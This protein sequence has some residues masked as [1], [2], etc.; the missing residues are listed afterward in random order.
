MFDHDSFLCL[1]RLQHYRL[2][3]IP[4]IK[5]I[6]SP[7]LHLYGTIIAT[8]LQELFH[9]PV[10]SP[11]FEDPKS[12][13]QKAQ[14]H[15]LLWQLKNKWTAKSLRDQHRLLTSLGTL[16]A[17]TK[18]N[19]CGYQQLE[20]AHTFNTTII[21]A[22]YDYRQ[23]FLQGSMIAPLSQWAIQAAPEEQSPLGSLF[24][25]FREAVDHRLASLWYAH[26]TKMTQMS[27]IPTDVPMIHPPTQ[28]KSKHCRPKP[29]RNCSR[30]S[31]NSA[32]PT[33]PIAKTLK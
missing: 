18:K 11:F 29:Y 5:P 9:I 33:M 28:S 19:P 12:L 23:T 27:K 15:N 22:C 3:H 25:S 7:V 17:Y 8:V 24:W 31:K 16:P 21:N 26:Q 1:V 2:R 32:K 20:R 6:A 13:N 14:P 4:T 30:R 10:K